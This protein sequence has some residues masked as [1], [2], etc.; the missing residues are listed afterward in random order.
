M[1]TA[2]TASHSKTMRY[3]V[4]RIL[5]SA[6]RCK[7]VRMYCTVLVVSETSPTHLFFFPSRAT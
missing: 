1:S 7:G 6:R 3:D 2:I 4:I 5:G